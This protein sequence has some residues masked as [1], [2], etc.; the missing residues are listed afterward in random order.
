MTQN[1]SSLVPRKKLFFTKR[2]MQALVDPDGLVRTV[3][4]A[5]SL[6]SDLPSKDRLEYKGIKKKILKVPVQRLVLI[7]PVEERDSKSDTK[8]FPGGQAGTAPREEVVGDLSDTEQ[9]AQL[10]GEGHGSDE[11]TQAG[12]GDMLLLEEDL[13]EEPL[14]WQQPL[15]SM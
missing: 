1:F 10:G 2:N 15:M 14:T 5:Y 11:G 3:T 6:L 13:M 12:E 9:L 4:V 7:L 8:S